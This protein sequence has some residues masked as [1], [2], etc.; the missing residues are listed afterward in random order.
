MMA[1]NLFRIL[2][3]ANTR[4]LSTTNIVERSAKVNLFDLNFDR[5]IKVDY[6]DSIRYLESEAYKRTYQGGLVWHLY[7]RNHKSLYPSENTRPNCINQEGFLNTSYP[8]SI[9]RDEYLVL[10]PENVKLLSQFIDPYTGMIVERKKHGLCL[11]QYRNLIISVHQAKD[12]GLLIHEL[13]DR[14]YDYNDYYKSD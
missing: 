11:K 6:K 7:K 2:T 9:C 5:R 12:L 14:L 3:T 13:P 4:M 10:H 8:C 1:R